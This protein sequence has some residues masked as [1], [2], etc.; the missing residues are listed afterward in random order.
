MGAC[1][2]VCATLAV[3]QPA[4]VQRWW[5]VVVDSA[6]VES[7]LGQ[8]PPATAPPQAG[9]RQLLWHRTPLKYC[10]TKL[11]L[12]FNDVGALN[13]HIEYIT[14]PLSLLHFLAAQIPYLICLNQ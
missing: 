12:N 6:R 2:G 4:W 9:S 5:R 3:R 1:A 11:F 13:Q 8:L 10:Q 14:P 7:G